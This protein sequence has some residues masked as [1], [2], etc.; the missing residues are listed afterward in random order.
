MKYSK[1]NKQGFL[2]RKQTLSSVCPF[3]YDLIDRALST[4]KR[5]EVARDDIL[6]ALV[7][8]VTAAAG[9]DRLSSLPEK[10]EIDAKGLRMEMVYRTF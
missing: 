10:P 7:A 2:E 1:K 8:A 3:T 6:D 9:T 5:K 4:W